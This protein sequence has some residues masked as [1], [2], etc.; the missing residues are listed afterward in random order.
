MWILTPIRQAKN[1]IKKILGALGYDST[2]GSIT[3]SDGTTIPAT[4]PYAW[5]DFIALDWTALSGKFFRVTDKHSVGSTG[6]SIWQADAVG[7]RPVLISGPLLFTNV[8]DFPTGATYIGLR[9]R[10]TAVGPYGTDYIMDSGQVYRMVAGE[11]EIGGSAVKSPIYTVANNGITWTAADNG[12]GKVRLT[13]SGAH[14][15]GA[16]V[17][18]GAS[19]FSKATQ[20]GWVANTAYEIGVYISTTVVDLTTN[21]NTGSPQGIPSIAMVADE[22]VIA[23]VTNP[24]MTAKGRVIVDTSFGANSGTAAKQPIIRLANS[25]GG[26]GGT[27]FFQ[28]A[29][30]GAT[31]LSI[32]PAPCVISNRNDTQSQVGSFNKDNATGVG[33]TTFAV[34]P[35]GTIQTN[36]ATDIVI[37]LKFTGAGDLVWMDQYSVRQRT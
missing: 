23:T 30:Y 13:S 20:N 33:S 9:C 26:T 22:I 27:A 14:G 11:A 17:A 37:S 31:Q 34:S 3:D 7:D 19:V 24:P 36:V 10:A 8:S 12:S 5:A 29:A 15:I 16:G 6:G 21:W 35:T 28:P 18:V 25:G 32:H 4:L 1:Q 2:T